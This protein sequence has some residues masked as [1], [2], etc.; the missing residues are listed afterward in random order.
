MTKNT[1]TKLEIENCQLNNKNLVYFFC[2]SVSNILVSFKILPILMNK[3]KD[4]LIILSSLWMTLL[5]LS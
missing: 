2:Q 5:T 1:T 3:L 4:N